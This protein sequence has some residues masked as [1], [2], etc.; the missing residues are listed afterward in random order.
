[1]KRIYIFFLLLFINCTNKKE[2]NLELENAIVDYQ[3]K[4]PF[5]KSNKK[6]G[7]VFLYEVN[8]TKSKNDTLIQIVRR[9]SGVVENSDCFGVFFVNNYPVI[10]YDDYKISGHFINEKK[11]NQ[12]INEFIIPKTKK[13]YVDYPPVYTYKVKNSKLDLYAIDTISNK[14]IK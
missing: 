12:N 10:M 11:K 7:Y 13:Q 9:P 4:V 1:M 8:F 6:E 3:T 2:I 5:P 14:W